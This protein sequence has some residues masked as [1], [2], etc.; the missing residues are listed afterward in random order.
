M[1][2]QGRIPAAT[3]GLPGETAASAAGGLPGVWGRGKW[4]CFLRKR[5]TF[6][7]VFCARPFPWLLLFISKSLFLALPATCLPQ[8]DQ[9]PG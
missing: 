6:K 1:L 4:V 5:S 3:S 7:T 8:Y 2:Q 9:L